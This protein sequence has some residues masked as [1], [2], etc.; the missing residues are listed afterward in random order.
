MEKC[1]FNG[2][3]CKGFNTKRKGGLLT[4]PATAIKKDPHER[5]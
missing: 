1:I 3:G 5:R 2:K 4:A